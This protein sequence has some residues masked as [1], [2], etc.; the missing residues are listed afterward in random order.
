MIPKTPYRPPWAEETIEAWL[1]EKGLVYVFRWV[2]EFAPFGG[3]R[4]D[5][6]SHDEWL[7]D[8]KAAGQGLDG[9]M[10]SY[11]QVYDA[12]HYG[13]GGHRPMTPE[14]RDERIADLDR[15][16]AGLT[17]LRAAYNPPSPEPA[18]EQP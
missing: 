3:H 8:M 12:P 4:E 16:I 11:R 10:V 18:Q 15:Q 5:H 14:E 2:P 6:P 1:D 7:D 17:L 9:P 13:V